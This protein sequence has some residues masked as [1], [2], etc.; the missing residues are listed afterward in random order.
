[1]SNS[2]RI[3][4]LA[5][6][7][8][9]ALGGV[10]R[11]AWWAAAAALVAWL[12]SG[13]SSI[14]ANQVGFVRRFGNVVR[15]DIEP[16]LT[17]LL[18]WPID[19]LDTAPK[20]DIRRSEGG[21]STKTVQ[22]HMTIN[23]AAAEDIPYSLTGDQNIIHVSMVAQYQIKDPYQYLYKTIG[24]DT[25]LISVLNDAIL[26]CTASMTIDEV[27]TTKKELLRS[28]ARQLAQEML[29]ELGTGLF[30]GDL[31]LDTPPSVPKQ[32]EAAFQSV[33]D[34]K[35]EM[36]T[37]KYR[38][39]EFAKKL[40]GDAEGTAAGVIG[41]AYAAKLARE[42]QATSDAQRFLAVL[43]QYEKDKAI[44][45]LRMYLST[46]DEIMAKVKTYVLPAGQV[47]PGAR[48]ALPPPLGVPEQ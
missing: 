44:T 45:R 36:Q 11:V 23:S 19:R 9:I 3:G 26:T 6:D 18:P 4:E 30:I 20:K 31:Q 2:Q 32:T 39:Q 40:I 27:L 42:Q 48:R 17:F 25:V 34:A 22:N 33:V 15:K 13:V 12:L 14:E 24:P 29:D 10:K 1:M 38:A 7:L 35:V 47:A 43:E 28:E 41:G 21:F 16:G 5:K 46:M 8:R 37:A